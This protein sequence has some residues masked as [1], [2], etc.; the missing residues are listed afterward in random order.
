MI[1]G[2]GQLGVATHVA[3]T[4]MVTLEDKQRLATEVLGLVQ[5]LRTRR[6]S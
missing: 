2:A 4:L 5:S 6:A 3:V 1:S